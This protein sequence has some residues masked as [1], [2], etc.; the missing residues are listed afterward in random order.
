MKIFFNLDD[1]KMQHRIRYN[2]YVRKREELTTMASWYTVER[3][4]IA[5][6]IYF[7]TE[8]EA[9]LYCLAMCAVTGDMW[10]VRRWFGYSAR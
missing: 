5:C 10:H 9:E 1:E 2:K 7:N 3:G 6:D 8:A 4:F